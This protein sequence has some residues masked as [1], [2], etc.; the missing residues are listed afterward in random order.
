MFGGYQQ[1][2]VVPC[3]NVEVAV[4]KTVEV[5]VDL[6]DIDEEQAR[7]GF[8]QTVTVRSQ[9]DMEMLAAELRMKNDLR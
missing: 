4:H 2:H 7:L 9:A 6:Q 5:D 8:K 1:P 3:Q